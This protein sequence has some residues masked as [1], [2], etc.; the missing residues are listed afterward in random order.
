MAST[1]LSNYKWQ[2][3]MLWAMMAGAAIVILAG[4][5]FSLLAFRVEK[6]VVLVVSVFIS[7]LVNRYQAVIPGTRV[8]FNAKNVFAFWGVIWLGIGG[9]VFLGASASFTRLMMGEHNRERGLFE[10]CVDIIATYFSAVTFYLALGFFPSALGS[11]SAGEFGNVDQTLAAMLSMGVLHFLISASLDYLMQRVGGRG[12]IKPLMIDKFFRPAIAYSI[13]FSAAVILYF[14]FVQFGVEFGLVILPLAVVGDLAYRMHCRSLAQK[15]KEI[16]DA[17]RIHLATVEALAT[18]I[19]ARDQVGIGHV[20]RTQIYA[21]GIGE[22]LELSDIEIDAL[23]TAALLH[24]IGK[25]AVPDHILN[26]P[27]RLTPAELEKAKIHASVGASILEKVGFRGPVTPSVKYHHERWDGTGYPEQLKG[28]NIPLT[29]RVLA[30]A[31]TYDTLRGA[32]PYR[33]AI[34]REEACKYLLS[35]SGT[36]FDPRIVSVFLNI[37][38][39]LEKE[40]D[41]QGLAYS[42]DEAT[43]DVRAGEAFA[44]NGYVEQIK[45]ANHEVFTLYELARD[46][47]SSVNLHETLS[48][49]TK[50]IAEFVPFDTCTVYLVD[51]ADEFASAKHIDGESNPAFK[52]RRIRIGTGPTGKVLET[53]KA[54]QNADPKEDFVLAQQEFVQDY[55]SMI[56]LPLLADEKLIGAVTLYSRSVLRY[57]EEHMRL[58]ETISRIAADAIRKS[59]QHLIA[60]THALTDPMTGLPNARSLQMQ[61]EKERARADR[62]GSS[63]QVLMLDLDG[64]KQVN[65]NF[66]HKSGDK[67]LKEIGRII[68]EQ[69]RDYDFLARYAG[70]EFVALVPEMAADDVQDLCSRIENAIDEFRLPVS[71][72]RVA[73]VGVSVGASTYPA[74]GATFDEMVIAADRGMYTIKSK[75]KYQR[76]AAEQIEDP[77][78]SDPLLVMDSLGQVVDAS[79]VHDV[80]NDAFIVE[81]DETHIVSAAVN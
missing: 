50:K 73:Q 80:S 54:V 79:P 72:G 52:G 81:L 53:R 24:D 77:A 27:G 45:R 42:K 49:F 63:F 6:V 55:V 16:S 4:S 37:L 47:G 11:L 48:L 17:S 38:R 62:T 14:T 39:P 71:E 12:E 44:S 20:R 3:K 61:F 15:T 2:A 9:G 33:P 28:T 51:E 70:D 58:L 56:S 65:D 32:R 19:D 18:A 66:G 1:A 74:N 59:L 46:F 7:V 40:I 34:S 75:R 8:T 23:R 60:E 35:G 5:A 36:Q 57:Q 29:A 30:V 10:G 41:A 25:L 31:D 78:G 13:S 76:R 22:A 67:M 26:K 64:F 43:S 21:M 69:L 68:R